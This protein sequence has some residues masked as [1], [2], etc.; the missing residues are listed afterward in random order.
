MTKYIL[1]KEKT[2]VV[3]INK[4]V[5]FEI[6][7]VTKGYKIFWMSSVKQRQIG[8]YESFDRTKEILHELL[9]FVIS[10]SENEYY[11]MPEK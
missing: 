1:S 3:P 10:S 11:I 4:D 2:G 7:E 5:Y 6:E 9:M 8:Y